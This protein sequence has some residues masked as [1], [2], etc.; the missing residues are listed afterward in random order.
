MVL[1]ELSGGKHTLTLYVS[2]LAGNQSSQSIDFFVQDDT[3]EASLGVAGKDVRSSA[4][5][6]LTHNFPQEPDATIYVLNGNGEVVWQT[7]TSSFPCE[8]NLVGTDGKRVV[9]GL[10][11]YYGTV[12]YG[13]RRA[14]TP[15][16]RLVILGDK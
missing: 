14:S 12:S 11:R 7:A 8:W 2:D 1:N 3:A 16:Q 5:F 15:M 9:P 10:Y 13:N 4:V 6:E